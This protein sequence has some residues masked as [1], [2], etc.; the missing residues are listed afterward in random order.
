[1]SVRNAAD[2]A[3]PQHATAPIA[4]ITVTYNPGDYLGRC[5]DSA[6]AAHAAG[7]HVIVA[8]N[9]SVDGAP[10]AAAETYRDL[11]ELIP[12]GANLGYGTAMNIGWRRAKELVAQGLV[13]DDYLVIA[14]P[15]V[16][17]DPGSIDELIAAADRWPRAGALGPLIVEPDGTAYPSAR[18]VPNLRTGIGHALLGNIWPN[19]PF[20]AAYRAG[21]D[22]SRE[23]AAG[24]LSGSCLVVSYEAFEKVGGFDERYFMFMEDVDLGDRLTRAGYQNIL[25][26]TATITHAKGHAAQTLPIVMLNAHHES[27]YRF[28]SDRLP[29]WWQAPVRLALKVGLWLRCKILQCGARRRAT[30]PR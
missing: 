11:M 30:S 2:T 6:P 10:E 7:V 28:L 19:N 9:G 16:V 25:V 14:N 18:A 22:M 15:D 13:R 26:P 3:K 27:A 20:S 4:V 21:H 24:W 12:T 23:R 5:L 8:D 17:F 29:H 1:M